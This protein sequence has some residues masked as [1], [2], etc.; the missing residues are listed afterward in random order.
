MAQS[1]PEMG[2]EGA[3]GLGPP[4]VATP[5]PKSQEMVLVRRSE[6]SAL[7]K[8]ISR[9]LRDP[10]SALSGWAFTWLGVG[11][12]ATV[13]LL[14]TEAVKGNNVR[15]WVVEAQVGLIIVG[16]FLA[17]FCGWFAHKQ[18]E[19]KGSAVTEL[20]AEID[21]LDNR[22]PT[23]IVEEKVVDAPPP[24]EPTAA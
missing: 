20:H 6:L 24:V 16:F 21:D 15:T 3:F 19:A 8:G 14:G 5:T 13:S 9:A 4:P 2:T 18:S 10:L 11:A 7:K 22:A 1:A 17:A 12:A 23:K